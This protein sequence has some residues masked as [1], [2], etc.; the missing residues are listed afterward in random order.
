MSDED[1]MNRSRFGEVAGSLLDRRNKISSRNR[2]EALALAGLLSF[3][4][5]K[6]QKQ[7]SQ[8][9]ESIE[10]INRRYTQ[11]FN[12]NEETYAL[13]QSNRIKYQNYIN[14]KNEY[15]HSEAVKKFNTH[16][17][18]KNNFANGWASVNKNNMDKE[19]Y[20]KAIE[21]YN[22][23]KQ[24]AQDE[25]D[26]F[27]L[28]PA[29]QL[30]TFT[31]YNQAA[32]D[33]YNAAV[34]RVRKDPTKTSLIR[35]A[36]NDIFGHTYA[37]GAPKKG[38]TA[39]K[40]AEL[41]NNLSEKELRR[42]IQEETVTDSLSINA[43]ENQENLN[44]STLNKE[45]N[46]KVSYFYGTKI[47]ITYNFQTNNEKL[48][49]EKE[50]FYKKVNQSGYAITEDDMIFSI[51]HDVPL[52]GFL[53]LSKLMVS[54]RKILIDTAAAVKN[55]KEQNISPWE[56]G[57]LNDVQKDVWYQATGVDLRAKEKASLELKKI[58][59]ELKSIDY[60][61]NNIDGY[62][63]SSQK[64][65]LENTLI[66]LTK[67]GSKY[68]SYNNIFNELMLDTD[69]EIL[70]SNIFKTAEILKNRRKVGLDT[71]IDEAID[72]QL[73]GIYIDTRP[74]RF[75]GER[76]VAIPEFVD[77]GIL[78]ILSKKIETIQDA[79]DLRYALNNK[80]YVQKQIIDSEG[81]DLKPDKL[82]K[83]FTEGDYIFEV[84]N[85]ANENE[86]QLLVWDYEN[87]KL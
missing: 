76:D 29:I 9:K 10:N 19:E 59:R 63:N 3:I 15:L 27:Q 42:K 52:P 38:S 51:E 83:T 49:I 65:S 23:F 68:E 78:E 69:K 70:Y 13:Q 34:D 41:E 32:T 67:K 16:S 62:M 58:H 2:N 28:N 84:I 31:K 1:Y 60:N 43:Q 53:N 25:I 35:K 56:S 46:S 54:D 72:I 82:G 40:I 12:N 66:K 79:N 47:P 81:L 73:Q 75:Y 6:K 74:G 21:V 24:E 30:A 77:I 33:A 80:T 18:L 5:A 85:I 57:V 64:D 26:R 48:K 22:G 20:D 11:I 86:P 8:L 37:D 36:W 7:Q 39:Y 4:D 61:Q 71:V 14:N 17:F 44:T 50:E 45:T 87:N 55:L